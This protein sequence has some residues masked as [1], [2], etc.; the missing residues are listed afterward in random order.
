MPYRQITEGERYAMHALRMQ[1][2]CAA[3]IGRAMG[4]HRSTIAREFARNSKRF[5]GYDRPQLADWYARTRRSSRRNTQFTPEHW[6]AIDALLCIDWSPEQ[7][8]GWYARF[9]VLAISH[10]TIYRHIWRDKKDGGSLHVHLRRANKPFRKR[11]A[12]YDSR[13]RLAGKRPIASRP[14]GAEDRSQLGHW[15]GDTVLGD[16]QGG[17]CILTRVDRKSRYTLIGKLARRTGNEVKARARQLIRAQP[18]PVHT[19]TTDNGTEFHAYKRLEATLPTRFYFATPHHSWE[20][21]TNENTNGLIR[22]YLPKRVSMEH[23]TQRD[24]TR[25]AMKLN[26]R[27]RKCLGFRTP[28]ECYEP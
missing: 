20:R 3:A 16:S 7:I 14:I 5:D 27:P 12:H 22:Q 18:R 24:C 10:E 6:A 9:G 13:G 21:G 2:L 17:A 8:V 25:I 19:I 23:L 4:R 28:E 26:Q 11:Y 1:G 15:E